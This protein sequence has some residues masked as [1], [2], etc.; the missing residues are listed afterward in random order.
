MFRVIDMLVCGVGFLDW[1][2]AGV[3]AQ[4]VNS[5][6]NDAHRLVT[7][8]QI[9]GVV[10]LQPGPGWRNSVGV[11]AEVILYVV[12]SLDQILDGS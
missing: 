11:S 8:V 7:V 10:E 5:A 1:N 6:D 2:V 4:P 12:T 9:D 3:V